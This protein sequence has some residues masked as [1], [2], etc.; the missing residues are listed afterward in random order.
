MKNS[1]ADTALLSI[2]LLA[3]FVV[4][5]SISGTALALP[6]IGADIQAPLTSLQWVVNAFNLAFACFTL[7]WGALADRLGRKRCFVAGAS[8]YVVASVLS[9]VADSAWLLDAARGLAGIGAAAIFS[10][11][12]A[13]LSTHFSGPARLRAFALFGTVA[14]LGV[15]LG[16]TLSGLLLDSVGWRAIFWAHA[17]TLVIVLLGTPLIT[18]D[19]ELAERTAR[20]DVP[21]ATLFVL[22]LLALMV[23]IV[24]GSQWGW[25]SPGVLG[26]VAVAAVLL[27]VFTWQERRHRQPM[28]DLSLLA[29]GPFVGLALVTVA[30]SF[31]FVTLLTY[32]PSYLF[33]V[34]QLSATHAGL[35][36]LLLT[37]PM[38]FCPILAGKWAAR[39][40]SAIG[41]LK[42]SL[43]ALLVGVV[44]L[45]LV[46]QVSVAL[47]QLAVPLLL[48]GIGMGLSA[49]LVDGLALKTVPEQKAGMAAG[50]LNTFRLGSEAIAVALYGSLL[51]TLLDSQLRTTLSRLAP[52]P[53]TLQRWIDD[54][55]AGNLT[56]SLQALSTEQAGTVHSLFI[57]GYDSAFHGVLWVL[58]AIL[59]VLTAVVAWLVRP[60][61]EQERTEAQ[62][63]AN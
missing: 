51:A 48:V 24:Q 47:W 25:S 54:V 28:L 8:L 58:A 1:F 32:L 17:V 35:A 60:L 19:G 20:F 26:L 29:S 44:S 61:R 46:S 41:I 43:I 52:D 23:A 42:V 5:S 4:P 49:G 11:G 22:A 39:G 31:G 50:L 14:G 7:A 57:G 10:C 36:M 62:L 2:I 3:I 63:A 15:S 12:I 45:A 56:G 16:P 55:A 53:S 13:I 37:V 21:G 40:V 34:L 59:L 18:R 33:G 27:A 38:L 30:A 9:A 6:A